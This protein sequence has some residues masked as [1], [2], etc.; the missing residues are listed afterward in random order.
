MHTPIYRAYI[1]IEVIDRSGFTTNVSIFINF[2]NECS[3]NLMTN[4]PYLE[5]SSGFFLGASPGGT[6]S[7]SGLSCSEPSPGAAPLSFCFDFSIAK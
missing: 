1:L 5:R 7:T 4:F 2:F 6:L 3:P